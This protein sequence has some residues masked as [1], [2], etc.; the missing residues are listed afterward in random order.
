LQDLPGVTKVTDFGNRQDLHLA[1]DAD[2][3]QILQALMARG[4]IEHFEVARPSLRDIFVQI[5][6]GGES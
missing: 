3:Q 2:R 5:A 6:G 1:P 4:K